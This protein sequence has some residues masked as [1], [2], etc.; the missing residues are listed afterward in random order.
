MDWQRAALFYLMAL[1]LKVFTL[2]MVLDFKYHGRRKPSL[3]LVLRM[4]QHCR[5]DWNRLP[6]SLPYVWLLLTWKCW[7]VAVSFDDLTIPLAGLPASPFLTPEVADA[8]EQCETLDDC[9]IKLQHLPVHIEKNQ[10]L[11]EILVLAY[12]LAAHIYVGVCL[13]VCVCV[14]VHA[15]AR[16]RVRV[17][18][19]ACNECVCYAYMQNEVTLETQE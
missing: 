14:C 1:E 12:I 16:A 6:V 11:Q 19:C 8:D 7:T 5:T 18:A 13:C 9:R 17:C 15:C 2:C 4:E 3:L 10:H